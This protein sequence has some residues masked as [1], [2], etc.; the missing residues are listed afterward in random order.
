MLNSSISVCMFAPSPPSNSVQNC[1]V[2][3]FPSDPASLLPDSAG[4]FDS[5]SVDGAVFPSL[6]LLLLL[7]PHA[8]SNKEVESSPASTKEYL[9]FMCASLSDNPPY[10]ET[11]CYC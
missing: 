10:L 8:L 4:A 6:L 2:T 7:P 5:V 1:R 3:A 11:K 9:F